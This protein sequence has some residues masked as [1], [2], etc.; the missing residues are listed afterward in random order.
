MRS[1]RSR[2]KTHDFRTQQDC[3]R[4]RRFELRGRQITVNA[5]AP[6]GAATELFFEGKSQERIDYFAKLAPLE[7]LGTPE[8]IANV[9]ASLSVQTADGLMDKCFA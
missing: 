4:H 7:R 8:D 2:R 5:V 1:R 9:V 6:G 3:Y